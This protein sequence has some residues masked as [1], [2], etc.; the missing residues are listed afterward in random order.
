[1]WN[2]IFK[3]T[4]W[5][6]KSLG[7]NFWHEIVIQGKDLVTTN[8]KKIFQFLHLISCMTLHEK[9]HIIIAFISNS[10]LKHL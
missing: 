1:L 6:L 8:D 10:R 4:S 7:M 9:M 5:R 3:Y 2:A